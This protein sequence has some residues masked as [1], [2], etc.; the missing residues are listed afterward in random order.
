MK[1]YNIAVVGATGMVGETVIEILA[2]R[3]F[4]IDQF[5]ALASEGSA[6]KSVYFNEKRVVVQVAE[7]FD[8]SKVDIAIFTAGATVSRQ[9]VPKATAAGC[10]VIDNTSAFRYDNDVPLVVS[11]VNP[12]AIA[13]FKTR[14]IISNP[15]CSTIQMLVALKPLH[16]RFG[17]THINIT[18]FQSVSG[19]GRRA[20]ETLASE[21]ASLLN[22]QSIEQGVFTKQIAFN[23]IPHI[24]V[25]EENGYTREEMKIVRETHKI[26]G[27]DQIQVNP[28]AVRVPVFFGHSESIHIQTRDP[29]D[30]EEARKILSEAPGVEVI[31]DREDG[32][33]PTAVSDAAGTDPVY[34]G[35]LRNDLWQKNALNLWVVADNVRKGGA[36]NSVQIAELLISDYL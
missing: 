1:L 7:T 13:Q 8:F 9:L 15:N 36:L 32:G 33:Y 28:T 5:Y 31:D 22:A 27:D 24:D 11:E 30:A 25:F 6:G 3:K 26:L 20:M 16:D 18:T 19:A 2:E 21:T 23:C 10:I 14:N 35:R 29:I 12:E 17:L 4:P 34:V